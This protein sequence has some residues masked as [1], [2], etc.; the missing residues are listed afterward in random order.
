MATGVFWFDVC[1]VLCW[2]RMIDLESEDLGLGPE[3]TPCDLG[4][5]T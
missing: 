2:T 3:L 5:L 1:A 4:Q